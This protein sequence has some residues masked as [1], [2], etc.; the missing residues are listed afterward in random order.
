MKTIQP[1][2]AKKG[3]DPFD[4]PDWIFETK[5]DGYRAL[6]Y[7]HE[8][9]KVRLLTRNYKDVKLIFPEIE[10]ALND[11]AS[12]EFILDGEIV[13]LD[14]NN[15]SS[16][17]LAQ[18][19]GSRRD[20]EAILEGMEKFPA[21]YIVYD[22]LYKSRNGDL[23]QTPLNIRKQVLHELFQFYEPTIED[24]IYE[25]DYTYR[26]GCEFF[27]EIINENEEGMIAKQMF[28]FYKSGKRSKD[29]LKIFKTFTSTFYICGYSKMD[30]IIKD[31]IGCIHIC[32]VDPSRTLWT[33]NGK[34]GTGFK[35]EERIKLENQLNQLP[36]SDFIFDKGSKNTIWIKP[37]YR[38]KIKFKTITKDAKLR[39]PVFIKLLPV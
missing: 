4:D 34:V 23:R 18:R 11:F 3:K 33:Y 7:K 6:A 25:A 24:S 36:T 2:L 30:S 39:H 9:G 27:D 37:F 12:E 21:K 26:Y 13:V 22:I 20:G 15:K 38:C 8:D 14:N 19:R 29:W 5:Y 35:Q 10:T 16:F 32:S 28:S 1:M 17:E 31:G